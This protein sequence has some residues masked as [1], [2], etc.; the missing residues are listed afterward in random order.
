MKKILLFIT[1]LLAL[2]QT[3]RAQVEWTIWEGSMNASSSGTAGNWD[4]SLYLKNT[5]FNNLAVGDILSFKISKN[6]NQESLAQ[7]AFYKQ[8]HITD[9]EESW[10]E[11]DFG[12]GLTTY[13]DISGD[14][15]FTVTSDILAV[16]NSSDFLNF[17]IAGRDFTLTKVTIRKNFSA[18]KTV[19]STDNVSLGNWENQYEIESSALSNITGGDYLYI[20]ATIDG[21]GQ[22]QFYYD[23]TNLYN[24]QDTKHDVWAEVQAADVDNIKANKM[25]VKGQNYNCTGLY[26]YHPI[27]FSIGSIG[28]ATFSADVAVS[29]PEGLEAYT[30]KVSGSS[31]VLTKID[32]GVIPANTGVI[33]KGAEGTVAEFTATTSAATPDNDLSA[34]TTPTT[35]T[36]GDYVLYNNGGS[37]EFRKVTATTLAANKAFLQASKLGS[38]GAPSLSIVFDDVTTAIQQVETARPA[39]SSNIY[40]LGGQR[41]S[42]PGK[43]LYI[44]GGKKVVVK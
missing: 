23:W 28:M 11:S 18:I 38:S 40:T 10:P 36:A 27:A 16:F 21:W 9:P 24:V 25:H 35:M 26:L 13:N 31:L 7:I 15:S 6:A 1:A 42:Q 14:F 29:V 32:D 12:G 5:N 39:A 30:A 41:V 20:P 17:R 19:L 3:A 34:N 33:I 2:G 22:V 37:A 8:L 43:G 4:E 44:V